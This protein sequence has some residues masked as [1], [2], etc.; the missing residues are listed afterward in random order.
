MDD[1]KTNA[2]EEVLYINLKCSIF[3]H[4]FAPF[5]ALK[6]FRKNPRSRST[7]LETGCK[8]V[9]YSMQWV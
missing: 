7:G 8:P 5:F 6:L 9:L 4:I 3:E 1:L 2:G